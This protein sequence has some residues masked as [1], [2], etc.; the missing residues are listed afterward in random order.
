MRGQLCR[1]C[2]HSS[3]QSVPRHK[4]A[5]RWPAGGQS[6][7]QGHRRRL[8]DNQEQQAQNRQKPERFL[9]NKRGS[10]W[11]AVA[12]PNRRGAP[13]FHWNLEEAQKAVKKA[14]AEWQRFS[15]PSSTLPS[16]DGSTC[17]LDRVLLAVHDPC[18]RVYGPHFSHPASLCHRGAA[19]QGTVKIIAVPFGP[20]KD[21]STFPCQSLPNSC[22]SVYTE[23]YCLA[24]TIRPSP[25]SPSPKHVLVTDH[26]LVLLFARSAYVAFVCRRSARLLPRGQPRHRVARHR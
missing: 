1:R 8:P 14:K 3:R 26:W 17:N 16:C 13:G 20:S 22:S 2:L 19:Q 11:R 6:L 15:Q 25:K 23:N 12:M 4:G 5:K 18:L 7:V 21:A 24:S 10:T 9:C